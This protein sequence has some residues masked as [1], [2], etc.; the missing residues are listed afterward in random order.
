M[1][2]IDKCSGIDCKL[3][4]KCYRFL[5]PSSEP[6]QWWCNHEYNKQTKTCDYFWEVETKK[7]KK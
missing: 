2:D 3:K 4:Q 7:I 5:A 6:W 1:S